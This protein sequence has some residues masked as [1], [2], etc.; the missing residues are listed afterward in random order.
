MYNI[1]QVHQTNYWSLNKTH[2]FSHICPL[3]LVH[4]G[5]GQD[6][7]NVYIKHEGV[8]TFPSLSNNGIV[9]FK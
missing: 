5:V 6:L 1:N 3:P 7:T 4:W 2:V 8:L 9:D